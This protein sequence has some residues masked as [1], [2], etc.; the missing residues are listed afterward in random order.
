M[1][2]IEASDSYILSDTLYRCS[3][4]KLDL[5]KKSEIYAV[6]HSAASVDFTLNLE[7]S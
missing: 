7:N 3:C 6:L 1:Q 5:E 4:D 2:N